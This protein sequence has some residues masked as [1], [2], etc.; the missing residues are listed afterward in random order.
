[1]AIGTVQVSDRIDSLWGVQVVDYV[2]QDQ[3]MDLQ[4]LLVAVCEERAVTIEKGIAPLATRM[5]MTNAE[6]EDLGNLL[7]KF[8]KLQ[9]QYKQTEDGT[10][11]I[12]ISEKEVNLLKQLGYTTATTSMTLKRS[13]TEM[14]VQLIKTGMD[15]LNN[16][17]QTRM[18]RMNGLVEKRDGA[19]TSASQMMSAVSDTR[20]NLIAAL[21]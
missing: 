11:S 12:T 19:F 14:I 3:L 13:D 18:T 5:R 10:G 17:S 2:Y 16:N 20:K 8:S 21:P 4:D 6:L 1:M 9:A 7:S 15:A